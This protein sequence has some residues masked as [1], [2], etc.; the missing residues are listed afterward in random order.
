MD[1]SNDG[2]KDPGCKS[3]MSYEFTTLPETNE[4]L[5]CPSINWLTGLWTQWIA[6]KSH[7]ACVLWEPAVNTGRNSMMHIY[8]TKLK[9][10][11]LQFLEAIRGLK[12][13]RRQRRGERSRFAYLTRK[14][15][16]W[17]AFH[18][19]LFFPFFVQFVVVFVL[20][21]TYFSQSEIAKEST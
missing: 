4:F 18:V 17:H 21:G 19:F 14:N 16:I 9:A 6:L 10:V 8:R 1:Q 5:L 15:R 11:H 13:L 12:E 7:F 3:S 2:I 20:S